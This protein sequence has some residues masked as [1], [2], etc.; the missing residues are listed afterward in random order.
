MTLRSARALA[1]QRKINCLGTGAKIVAPKAL[2]SETPPKAS[3][4]NGRG[5]CLPSRL[6]GAS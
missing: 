3:G 1:E 4:G 2:R 5:I 6:G